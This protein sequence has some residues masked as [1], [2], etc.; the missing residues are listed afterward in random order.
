MYRAKY[1]GPYFSSLL[2]A[3]I[4]HYAR[5]RDINNASIFGTEIDRLMRRLSLHS[6]PRAASVLCVPTQQRRKIIMHTIALTVLVTV[7]IALVALQAYASL[8]FNTPRRISQRIVHRVAHNTM[9]VMAAVVA[10]AMIAIAP[11][12]LH[13][14]FLFALAAPSLAML[15]HTQRVNYVR[16]VFAVHSLPNHALRRQRMAL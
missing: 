5:A 10:I 11:S 4:M 12:A 8:R 16:T 15:H 14:L 3:E 1:L 2:L 7:S 13:A 9:I 6:L